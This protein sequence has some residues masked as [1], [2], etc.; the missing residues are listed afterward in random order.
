MAP[1]RTR[2]L[3]TRLGLALGLLA[4]AAAG[5]RVYSLWSLGRIGFY[6]GEWSEH[7]ADPDAGY[8]WPFRA[9]VPSSIEPGAPL[10][11]WVRPNNTGVGTSDDFAVHDEDAEHL[12]QVSRW[13]A[14]ELGAVVLVP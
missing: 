9:Y 14:E 12:L 11:I 2:T 3:L 5:A 1:T 13:Q 4:L 6:S 10:R 8:D 7:A